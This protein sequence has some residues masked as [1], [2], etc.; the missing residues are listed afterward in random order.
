MIEVEGK[1]LLFCYKGKT[2]ENMQ[3]DYHWLFYLRIESMGWW[4]EGT[5]FSQ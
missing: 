5:N 2:Y 3:M 4:E 1:D